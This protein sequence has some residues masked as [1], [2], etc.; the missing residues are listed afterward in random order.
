M[1]RLVTA[2]ALTCT[3]VV[4]CTHDFDVFETTGTGA[5]GDASAGGGAGNV[6]GSTGGIT[7][8]SNGGGSAMGGSSAS[9][10]GAGN[11]AGGAGGALS[12]AGE[13]AGGAG[14][15]GSAG[16]GGDA[17]DAPPCA[18]SQKLCGLACVGRDSPATGC[19]SASCSGCSL[20][21]STGA[22]CAAGACAPIGCAK[23]FGD[24]NASRSDGCEVPT[25]TD[26]RNCGGCLNDCTMQNG[27]ACISSVCGCTRDTECRSGQSSATITCDTGT[28]LCH[29]DAAICRRGES[30][31]RQ[32]ACSCN[33]QT[34]CTG[35]QT[36]CRSPAGCRDLGTD[37]ASCGACGHACA[38]GFV[39][40]AG[41]CQCDGDGDCSN[42][43][44]G[45]CS[46]GVCHC[47]GGTCAAGERCL[48][49]G[50]C[51]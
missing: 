7:G 15:G 9:T 16:A 23:G 26:A 2:L 44:A 11:L 35:S 12:D 21:N 30:C 24:C 31:S 3:L 42:G 8:T 6:D 41:A 47:D 39:C 40:T 4:A 27:K 19:D 29:C 48:A 37:A 38:T 18:P 50:K 1:R 13:N 25:A 28:N 20:A 5:S 10:G 34:A 46:G 49:T 43:T 14:A 51:G 32:G 33:G 17:P 36:C 45:T 22:L